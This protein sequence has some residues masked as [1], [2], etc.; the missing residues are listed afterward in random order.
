MRLP[1]SDGPHFGRLCAP[2]RKRSIH[3]AFELDLKTG[4]LR[5]HGIRVRLQEQPRRVLELLLQNPGEVVTRE[6]LQKHLWSTGIFVD[7]E[8]SLNRAIVRLRQ[9]LG[10]ESEAPRYV[11][12]VPRRGYRFLVPVETVNRVN[13]QSAPRTESLP[14]E[15]T[16]PALPPSV[17]PR[18][19]RFVLHIIVIVAVTLAAAASLLP[20]PIA[21]LLS[22]RPSHS[23]RSVA[24]LP[25]KNLSGDSAQDYFADGITDEITT[26]LAR[27]TSLRVVS[28]T[29]SR[30]YRETADSLQQIARELNVDAVVEG[31]VARSGS[32]VRVNAQFID[33]H[34][35]AH[36]WAQIYERD[37][38]EILEIQDSIA[39]EV[40]NQVHA[41]L[42]REERE[43]FDLRK[44]V[45]PEAYDAYLRGR[46]ELGNQRQ[47]ALRKGLEYFKQS[48][49]LDRLYAPAYS[50]MAD[51][52]SLLA[53]YG[54]MPPNEAFP[55]AKSAALKALDLDHTLAEGH[56][57]L[58]YVRHHFDWDWAGAEEEYKESI[59]LDPSNAIT[60]LR[61][62]EFLSNQGRH[63]QAIREVRQAHELAPR[64]LV[65]QSNIGRLLYYARRYD[66][67]IT[68]LKSILA[69]DPKRVYARIY[70]ALCY[71]QKQMY[72]E[73]LAEFQQVTAA[74]NG[75]EG[76]G[77]AHLYA[78]MGKADDARR[79]LSIQEQPPPDGVQDWFYIAGV[80]AQLG[81]KDNAFLWLERAYENRDF[82]V[83]FVN[84]DPQMDP[85][86][87]DPRFTDLLSR[88]G[89]RQ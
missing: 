26:D 56:T 22:W 72:P 75:Q 82:F 79:I 63:D 58:A 74:F 14:M 36:V 3:Q 34:N 16:D 47:E 50:G 73:A 43:S 62:A 71:E 85:L 60:H 40:A 45:V 20:G 39:L 2:T 42:S 27:I 54:G 7:F 64:S 11:E 52:Y 15:L 8:R 24:V 17:S 13:W 31:S 38:G 51:A 44:T 33:A 1:G 23:T 21:S 89:L 49:A 53:N 46:S 4:E 70:L 6:E 81:D 29:T 80:Y 61:Y 30:R 68:E 77:I 28:A 19:T 10:D 86:R 87:S 48:I 84:V 67:G 83:T 37:A 76:I 32:R 57:S 69:D 5:K 18:R 9:S 78:S 66:E 25:L 12:T 88:I 35:D 55:R 41:N 59:Q 65:V